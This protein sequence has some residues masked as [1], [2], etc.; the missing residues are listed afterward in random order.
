MQGKAMR[1]FGGL[2][3]AREA[4]TNQGEPHGASQSQH[5]RHSTAD[6]R[7]DEFQNTENPQGAP[8]EFPG[9]KATHS[10]DPGIACLVVVAHFHGVAADAQQLRHQSGLG[11]LSGRFAERELLLAAKSLGLK[12]RRVQVNVSRL[13]RTPL[14]VLISRGSSP[15][16]SSTAAFCSKSCCCP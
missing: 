7:G 4:S 15:R 5:D 6:L 8:A 1:S 14:P 9:E 3:R 11:S 13:A 16:S 2:N 10:D 12:A